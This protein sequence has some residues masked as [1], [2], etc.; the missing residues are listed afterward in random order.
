MVSL[1]QFCTHGETISDDR[2]PA[3]DFL[4]CNGGRLSATC[5][6]VSSRILPRYKLMLMT[7]PIQVGKN[8]FKCESDSGKNYD[9]TVDICVKACL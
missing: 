2:L 1:V 6:A 9:K 5:K 8:P 4:E 7:T 3:L